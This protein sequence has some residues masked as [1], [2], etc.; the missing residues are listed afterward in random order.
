MF[1]LGNREYNSAEDVCTKLGLLSPKQLEEV[2]KLQQALCVIP[3]YK[4]TVKVW[5]IVHQV[6]INV[7]HS[8]IEFPT[9]DLKCITTAT[10][11]CYFRGK[12]DQEFIQAN[13]NITTLDL[14]SC[15]ISDAVSGI[16]NLKFHPLKTIQFSNED[17]RRNYPRPML[18]INSFN[19]FKLD[20]HPT[21]FLS[22]VFKQ[23]KSV[24]FQEN[25]SQNTSLLDKVCQNLQSVQYIHI[26]RIANYTPQLHCHL[27]IL[28][29][30]FGY[31]T[32]RCNLIVPVMNPLN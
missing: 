18:V 29:K 10:T 13:P 25:Y 11:I 14:A 23:F 28:H 22:E 15:E 32:V 5:E 17:H 31:G 1:K 7:D 24:E 16:L 8:T 9:H 26:P 19:I 3:E 21:V 4:C 12:L 2:Q 30:M 27:M 6:E 20:N